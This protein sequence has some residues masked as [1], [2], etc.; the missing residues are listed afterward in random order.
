MYLNMFY[1]QIRA[2]NMMP[3]DYEFRAIAFVFPLF[4]I[5]ISFYDSYIWGHNTQ[6]LFA[7]LTAIFYRSDMNELREEAPHQ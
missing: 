1:Q 7:Y 4:F 2:T 6:V 3:R 5:L